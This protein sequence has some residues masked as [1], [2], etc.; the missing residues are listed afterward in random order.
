MNEDLKDLLFVSNTIELKPDKK[1][2]LVFKGINHHQLNQIQEALRIR[3]FDCLC[4]I[5]P[6]DQDVQVIEAPAVT[7]PSSTFWEEMS[8]SLTLNE[9]RAIFAKLA[10]HLG[11]AVDD[12]G[13]TESGEGHRYSMEEAKKILEPYREVD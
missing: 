1:Y 11:I 2:L 10:T 5:A 7:E 8:K 3:G 12:A 9:R 13:D 4:I 6:H